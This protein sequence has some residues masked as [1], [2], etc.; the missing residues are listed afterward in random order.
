M[1]ENQPHMAKTD[2]FLH[3]ENQTAHT[4]AFAKAELVQLTFD[5]L[6]HPPCSPE[7]ALCDI[8][9]FPNLVYLLAGPNLDWNEEIIAATDT[10]FADIKKTNFSNWLKKLEHRR[11]KRV[12]LKGDYNDKEI[13]TFPKFSSFFVGQLL[14][15]PPRMLYKDVTCI[16][17][18]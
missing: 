3:H 16:A 6:G 11:D 14:I 13:A 12:E 18:K 7:L 15:G 4:S 8:F 2:V 10:Y 5:L 9:L 1:A 17:F